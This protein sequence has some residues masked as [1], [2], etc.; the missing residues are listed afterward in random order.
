M[1]LSRA[2]SQL[3]IPAQQLLDF[4]RQE[5]VRDL[6]RPI[7]AGPVAPPKTSVWCTC[8]SH[9]SA[10]KFSD[11]LTTRVVFVWDPLRGISGS[12]LMRVHQS[13]SRVASVFSDLE[14]LVCPLQ[15]PALPRIR[16]SIVVLSKSALLDLDSL[17]SIDRRHNTLLA[18]YVDGVHQE[19]IDEFVDGFLCA[20][21]TEDLWIKQHFSKPSFLVPHAIDSRFNFL[22]K[23]FQASSGFSCGYFGHPENGLFV[24]E[25]KKLGLLTHVEDSITTEA[26][27]AAPSWM[28]QALNCSSHYIARPTRVVGEARFKPFT[29]GFLAAQSDALAV[30][31]R[32]D[33]E[34]T[35]WLGTDYPFL[36]NDETLKSAV[37]GV[38]RLR[39][40]W[41]SG[42]LAHSREVSHQNRQISC[43]VVN[44]KA[45]GL[46]FKFFS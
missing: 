46:A 1:F 6:K 31:S 33:L 40:A 28:I 5:A 21:H 7:Y 16:N 26:Q 42:D 20:S 8:G 45:Y 10:V 35:Y 34:S 14:I 2:Y 13:A 41:T 27:N 24:D 37:D 30:A 32:L 18:D 44:A 29:K 43:P 12:T 19:D 23:H 17:S 9:E 25:L 11:C 4:L 15:H 36:V 22:R 39:D 38:E 3:P